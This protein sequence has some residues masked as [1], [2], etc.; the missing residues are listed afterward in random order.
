M[1]STL[2]WL[3]DLD[4]LTIGAEGVRFVFER[5]LP[6]YL[7]VGVAGLCA[8]VAWSV[9]RHVGG[10]RT[11]RGVLASLRAAL[12]LLLA[13]LLAGPAFEQRE[14]TVEP[15]WL[16]VLLDRSDSMNV[17]DAETA[18]GRGSRD[19]QLRETLASTAAALESGADDREIHWFG[20]GRGA[21]E[22]PADDDGIPALEPAGARHT[23]LGSAIGQALDRAAARPVA[24]VLVLSDGRSTDIPGKNE[25]RALQS[26][27]APVHV[28]PLGSTGAVTDTA[29]QDVTAPRVAYQND[30][31]PVSVQLGVLGDPVSGELRL[32]DRDTDGVL[33]SQ[34][35]DLEPGSH[36]LS[37]T[38]RAEAAGEQRW[39]VVFVP[40]E[41]DLVETN[42]TSPVELEIVDRPLRVL[43]L[44]GYPRW[45]Q[46]YLRNLLIREASVES[47]N[48]MLAANRRYL[49]DGDT[50]IATLPRSPEEWAEYDAVI[51]GDLN[52]GVL[53]D[54]QIDQ[55]RLYVAERGGG[56]IWIAGESF[57]PRSWWNTPLASLLPFVRTGSAVEPVGRPVQVTPTS[58]A[59]RL[60]VMRLDDQSESGWPEE[61]S[62]PTVAWSPLYW[63]QRIEGRML[64]P[65][66]Q[67]LASSGAIGEGPSWPLVTTMRYGAGRVVYVAT[68][69]IWRW[70]YGRGEVL[71]ERLWLQIMR[72]LGRERLVAGDAGYALQA[73]G[74]DIP[75][76]EPVAVTLLIQDQSLL[77]AAPESVRVRAEATE[78]GVGITARTEL[79]L[80]L[81]SN[82]PGR[83]TGVWTPPAAGDWELSVAD[84][85]LRA[86]GDAALTLTARLPGYELADPR[87]DHE[88]LSALA[89]LTGGRVFSPGDAE[90]V[91]EPGVFPS[92]SVRRIHTERE[93]IWDSPLA[94]ALVLL[95]AVSEWVGR[96]MMRLM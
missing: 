60:G 91:G 67:V 59:A 52:P 11:V 21:F 19:A 81:D 66:A 93:P 71:Y 58:E 89:D 74:T 10:R 2:A 7:W 25:L 70:R 31:T 46:R 41:P 49:Q 29:I 86:A 62:D 82:R 44:D 51:L 8:L 61:L 78:P 33:E 48:L 26:T 80:A 90:A 18:A 22:L 28:M 84:P 14:E 96:R 92:R 68:D 20:F 1:N 38:H 47:S 95:L 94:L 36:T 39:A 37:L 4:D 75:V 3:L 5:P 45:E 53:T 13:A 54:T 35:V 73:S 42:N 88:L 9:Y 43:Y 34:R 55:L 27:G 40:D 77:D 76:G 87:P 69:E 6:L 16:I 72:L 12:L 32:I 64:K 83:Y 56:L 30:P 79:D 50:E 15:D 85:S 23:E 24:G 57:T 63:A 17:E 65:T